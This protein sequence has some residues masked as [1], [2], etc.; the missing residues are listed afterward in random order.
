MTSQNTFI[1]QTDSA[2]TY[3]TGYTNTLIDVTDTSNVKV[4]FGVARHSNSVSLNASSSSNAS[5]FTFIR[6]GD[7]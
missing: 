4:R 3:N 5:Y 2:E 6:L 7:T 1:Q